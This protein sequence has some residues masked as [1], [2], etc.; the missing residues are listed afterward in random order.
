MSVPEIAETYALYGEYDLIAKI[1][2][3]NTS[4]L[5]SVIVDKLRTI[6]GIKDTKTLI[7]VEF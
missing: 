7:G 5:T 3:D 6:E 4:I 2:A 1:V